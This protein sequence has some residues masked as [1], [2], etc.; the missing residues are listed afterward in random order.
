MNKQNEA[1]A[2]SIL[3]LVESRDE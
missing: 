1:A 3:V 2:F